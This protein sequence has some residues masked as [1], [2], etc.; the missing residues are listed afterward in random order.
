VDLSDVTCVDHAGRRLLQSM[1]RGGVK[2]TGARLAIQ[3]ILEQIAE[4]G[5]ASRPAQPKK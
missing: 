4:V 3:D 2:F 5:Q 1:H